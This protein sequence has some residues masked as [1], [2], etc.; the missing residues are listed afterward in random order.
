G[1]S[2]VPLDPDAP[3]AIEAAC[4]AAPR[5][6][7]VITSPAR[8]ALVLAEAL[9]ARDGAVPLV[10][11]RLQE[12]DFGTWEGRPWSAIDRRESDPWAEDPI[13]RAP[14]GGEA[15]HDLL[16]RVRAA[17]AEAPP[18]ALIVTHAGPIR[19][20]HMLAGRADFRAAFAAPVPYATPIPITLPAGALS[21]GDASSPTPPSEV[22]WPGSP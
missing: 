10:D 5:A 15:F 8:R 20:A 12:L 19:A 21:N 11:P 16:A 14:P 4:A 1:R 18:G 13:H 7:P 9:A 2:E 6:L 3:K 17:L 22:P